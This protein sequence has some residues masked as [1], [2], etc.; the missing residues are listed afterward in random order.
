MKTITED[1]SP[2]TSTT[3]KTGESFGICKE[4]I[5][6]EQE[7]QNDYSMFNKDKWLPVARDLPFMIS[8]LCCYRLKKQPMHHY[9]KK[10]KYKPILATMA[11]E[12]RVR[13]QA[14]VRTGCNAYDAKDVKSTPMAF[15]TEQDVLQYIVLNGLEIASV[16]GEIVSTDQDGFQY[17]ATPMTCDGCKLSCT[18]CKRTG[19]MFC[20]FGLH[21]EKKGETRFQRLAKTHPK[22]Y[23]YALGG[24]QWADNPAYDPTA[25]KM[26]GEWQN[27]NPKKIWI[28]SDKG[29]GMRKVFEMMN[30]VY[31]K[32]FYRYE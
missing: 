1:A 9:Q 10:N 26:D 24:G 16:Y 17:P 6:S 13:L 3:Q 23:E 5:F 4:G 7:A 12:S 28:P 20:G 30:E 14:W 32:G 8:H 31:G 11:E 19:C 2:Q 15:W 27:W 21:L 18:G 22:Q 29:L 25:P